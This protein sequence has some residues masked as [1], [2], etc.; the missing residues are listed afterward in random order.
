MIE[1][2]NKK[3]VLFRAPFVVPVSGSIITD[4]AVLVLGTEIAA[5]GRY[6]DLQGQGARLVDLEQRIL[7]PALLNCHTHLE[8]SALA[9]MGRDKGFAGQDITVWIRALLQQRASTTGEVEKEAATRAIEEMRAGG[10]VLAA[11]IG[12]SPASPAIDNGSNLEIDFFLEFLGLNPAILDVFRDRLAGLEQPCTAHAPHTTHPEM[13]RFLKQR[14]LTLGNKFPLHVAESA[15][16]IEFLQ[17]GNG[18]FRDFI[19][20]RLGR[21][22][23]FAAPG[24]GALEYLDRLGVV[25]A[26]TICVHAVHISAVEAD[27]LAKRRAKV[28]LCP[29]SNRVL[30]VGKAKLAVLLD[31]GIKPCLGTDSLASNEELNLWRE[32][33]ILQ[34]DHPG[35]APAAIFAMA[36]KN[37][38]IAMG[39]QK[40]GALEAGKD[41][42]ILAV[43][44]KNLR[45]DEVY[46]YLV[47]IGKP[48]LSWPE[49]GNV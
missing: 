41:A 13:I 37:G 49:T 33:R 32:M 44:F 20:E 21:A 3:S 4:G 39:R 35:V 19:V 16:E 6:A 15:S 38:A 12:N 31:K 40:L 17:D 27:L 9:D 36:T 18:P 2:D 25:D 1:T 46:S 10:V 30:G 43:R 22:D 48:D 29:G 11:D 23:L 14:A 8:L 26:D 7:T 28:C 47:N 42:K 34:E 45:A 5:V 24:C